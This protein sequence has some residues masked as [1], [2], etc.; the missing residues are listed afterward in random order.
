[1]P[2]YSSRPRAKYGPDYEQPTAVPLLTDG[3]NLPAKKVI[4]VVGPI[5]SDGLTKALEEDL[6]N[7]YRNTLDMCRDNGIKSVAFCCVSTGVFRFPNKRA[8]EI[9]VQT[10][11]DWMDRNPG[12][13]ERVIFNVF[14]EEDKAYYETELQ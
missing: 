8:A 14:K 10:V 11:T 13:V 3:Y 1:M 5:V 4:H 12:Q 9:A 7:C 6:A 2:G